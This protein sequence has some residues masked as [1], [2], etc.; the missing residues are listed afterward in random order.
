M[1]TDKS[2]AAITALE[3]FVDTEQDEVKSKAA[4]GDASRLND[5]VYDWTR[6]YEQWD[7]WEDP[8][9]LAKQEQATRDR[10]ERTSRTQLGCAHD[11]SAVRILRIVFCGR[12][13]RPVLMAV[14]SSPCARHRSKS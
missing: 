8:E 1:A 12:C 14:F 2:K 9:E 7:A 3:R 13:C 6:T 11:H 5:S 10:R 4:K